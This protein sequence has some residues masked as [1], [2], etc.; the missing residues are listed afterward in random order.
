MIT[1][2]QN[3]M[4]LSLPSQSAGLLK[5][6][7]TAT[8]TQQSLCQGQRRIHQ[9]THEYLA[10]ERL[11]DR[12]QELPQQFL[13]PQPRPW[14]AIDWQAIAPDQLTGITVPTFLAILKGAI[15]TEAPIR[16]YTQTSRRYLADL[17]PQLARFVGGTVDEQG[18]LIELGLWEKEERQHAPALR[19]IYTRLSEENLVPIPH[20]VR[21]YQPSQTPRSDLYRHG[22]HRVLT[23]YGAT[24]L[25]LW[26]MAHSTGPLHQLLAELALDEINHMTKFWGFGVW[27]YPETSFFYASG[28]LL[29][30]M[31][32]RVKYRRDRSSL[33][34]TLDRMTAVLGWSAWSW[35]NRATFLY[36]CTSAMHQLWRW[37]RTLTRSELEALFG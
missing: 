18:Q 22:L 33:I 20:Q 5:S 7:P 4:T 29:Q 13:S 26:L 16:G 30:T 34:G 25:Y 17:H 27:A 14:K 8:P 3:A 31:Q 37:H 9:L 1:L 23:E 28:S 10:P 12:L 15:N 6:A 2:P 19:Q 36:T 24:C 35:Q 32:G 21:P 11:S